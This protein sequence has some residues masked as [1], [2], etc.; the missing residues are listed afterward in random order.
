MKLRRL[1]IIGLGEAGTFLAGAFKQAGVAEVKAYDILYHDPEKAGALRERAESAGAG[2]YPSSAEAVAD[3]D[4]A[5][6]T[7][8]ADQA[9]VAARQAAAGLTKGQTYLDLNSTSPANKREGAGLVTASGAQ[10]VDGVAMDALLRCGI[11]LPIL[12]P[13]RRPA[14][15]RRP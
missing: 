5:I 11:A 13:V 4:L 7:V 2:L 9:V 3:T 15:F 1:A 6:S 8:T 14:I 12:L 10:F